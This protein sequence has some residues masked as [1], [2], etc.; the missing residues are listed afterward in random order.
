MQSDSPALPLAHITVV[1]VEQAVAVPYATRQLADLGARVIKIE[2]PGSGD[3]ARGYDTTVLGQSSY[4][5]WLNRGKE[6][7]ALDLKQPRGLA[8]LH[9]L[10]AGADVYLQ[11]LAPGA[12]AR[13]GIDARTLAGRYP[14]LVAGDLSGYGSAGPWRHR[15]AY[16][17]LIQCETG[18]VELTGP[19]ESA[20][21][22][23]ISIADVAGGM[24][25]LTG[26]LA[27]LAAREHTGHGGSFEVSLLDSLAEWLGQ[28][29]HFTDGSGEPPPRTGLAHPSISPYGPYPAADGNV[30]I[31]VQNDREWRRFCTEV[32]KD[33]ALAD[34][35]EFA[36]NPAR[37]AARTALDTAITQVTSALTTR[38]LTGRLD[39]AEI[40]NGKINH[41]ADFLDHPQLTARQ[42]W[43]EVSTPAGVTRALAP[44]VIY[45]DA[46]PP[47]MPPVPAAGEHTAA[48]L[49][50]FGLSPDEISAV[51]G[52]D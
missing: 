39:A 3:F 40:A 5:V 51:R 7:V 6:S 35:P 13:L 28:P 21:R 16:D 34:R 15:K 42:R 17:L 22:A 12:A 24:Y 48:V 11:N 29:I 19:A 38:E 26:V 4:F 18:L 32:L 33:P 14:D 47:P 10:I 37:V 2:R 44:P 30:M 41:V 25:T 49:A 27:A 31:A 1:A 8:V 50:E 45:H 23:G 46:P 43:H 52:Q 20:A 36:T 9:R